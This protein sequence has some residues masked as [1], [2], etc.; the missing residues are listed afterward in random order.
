[1]K[2]TKIGVIGCG[3]ISGA[4]L[5][6]VPKFDILEVAACAD[7]ILE[8]AQARAA[9]FN[10]PRACTRGGAARRPGNRDR[11]Q[12][13]HSQGALRGGHGRVAGGQ[14]RVER[15]AADRHR[16]SRDSESARLPRKRRACCVGCAPDTF[17]GAGHQTCRKLIDDGWIGEPI[18]RHRLHDVPWPRELASG[19]GILLQSRRRPDVRHGA[20]LPHRAGEPARP[21]PPRHRLH[22]RHLPGAHHH[23]PAEIRHGHHRRCAH[24][25]GGPARFRQRRH[26]HH[27]HQLRRMGGATAVHRDLRHARHPQRA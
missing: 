27:R 15:E 8:R 21:G 23:Q 4:Y 9:E 10:V 16:A 3:A 20:V 19:P 6:Q 1:M 11:G 18:A 13:D 5:S 17:L 25:C 2:R 26:R 12:P 7:L 22:A 14:E 24:A